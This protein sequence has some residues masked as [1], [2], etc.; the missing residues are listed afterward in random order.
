[1]AIRPSIPTRPAGERPAPP[2]CHMFGL[3]PNQTKTKRQA[4]SEIFLEGLSIDREKQGLTWLA[5]PS[6]RWGIN[7]RRL[8][9]P[10]LPTQ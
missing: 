9:I 8:A 7:R 4:E 3:Y 5:P 2:V 10:Y 1:M 6:T